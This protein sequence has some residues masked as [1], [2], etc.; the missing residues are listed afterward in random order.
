MRAMHPRF[1]LVALAVALASTA[2]AAVVTMTDCVGDPHIVV[3][4]GTQS[5]RI[6]IDPDDLV[7]HC[8][9]TP[10]PGSDHIVISAHDVTIEP[11]GSMSQDDNTKLQ[12]TA[13]GAILVKGTFVDAVNPNARL[14]LDAVGDMT[15]ENAS[16]TVGGDSSGGDLLILNCTGTT[17]KCLITATDSTFKS[18]HMKIEGQGDVTFTRTKLITNS[19]NDY[20]EI[21]SDMANVLLGTSTG[22]GGPGL[23]CCGFGGGGDG[24]DVVTGKEGNLYI[25][26]FG[27]IDLSGAN[28]LVSEFICGR[29]GVPD[30]ANTNILNA[31]SMADAPCTG[32]AAAPIPAGIDLTDASIRND[33]GKPG[34]ISFCADESR[35]TIG[36]GGATL[37]DDNTSAV[38]DYSDLNGCSAPP[39][40][41]CPNVSGTA[42][43]DG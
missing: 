10:L 22:G 14:E 2:R 9:L 26:A 6:E 41:G 37:I 3:Q 4:P 16:L 13:S 32:G 38:E 33:I 15:F 36:I 11:P 35:G 25:L 8:A 43:T 7:L 34:D 27:R 39:R 17:P 5:T 23:D 20:I 30:P 42:A 24:N 28:V 1:V 21:R 29:S 12:V 40:S 19:P 31:C 18:R